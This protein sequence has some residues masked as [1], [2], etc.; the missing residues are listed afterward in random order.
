[1]LLTTTPVRVAV[2]ILC[3]RFRVPPGAPVRLVQQADLT[4]P[5]VHALLAE[6]YRTI[7][8][9]HNFSHEDALMELEQVCTHVAT[10]ANHVLAGKKTF[11]V[12]ED[13][14]GPL[15]LTNLDIPGNV[16][17]LPFA[18]CAYAF[19]DAPTLALV[20]ALLTQYAPQRAPART[21]TVY[22][23]PSREDGEPGFDFVFLA[24][25]YDGDWPYMISRSVLTDGKRN[26]EEILNSHPDGS[27]DPLFFSPELA[28]L[29]RL[30]V[31]AVLYTTSADYRTERRA[32]GPRG[33][34][35]KHAMLSGDEV[36][37]L[38][39]RIRI[40][41]RTPAAERTPSEVKGT[42]IDK[43]FWVRGHWRR[44]NASWQDQRVRWIE[45]YLKGP[46]AAAIVERQYELVGPSTP[47]STAQ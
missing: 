5:D 46:D 35:A 47:R 40:G 12:S 18:A 3:Q 20:A 26:L 4:A 1:M 15:R 27:T 28:E 7:R 10:A 30:A 36:Y 43:R 41:A 19:T 39:G 14:A 13:L 37:Y 34:T 9:L 21:L 25:G 6:H 44:A 38:P 31:N 17:E 2:E 33:L 8:Q 11:W 32:P 23:H 16:L 29:L 42:T 22:V 24:D 45:P